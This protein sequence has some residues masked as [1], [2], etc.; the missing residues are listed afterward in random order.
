MERV[1]KISVVA[2]GPDFRVTLMHHNWHGM[3]MGN[4]VDAH[5]NIVITVKGNR[6][7]D[8]TFISAADVQWH[9]A[10]QF[11]RDRFGS[12]CGIC[13]RIDNHHV[14]SKTVKSAAIATISRIPAQG[15]G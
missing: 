5:D 11:G 3:F 2:H 14:F 12:N 9:N 10:A 4:A 13:H 15:S 6:K 8:L 7:V 1:G